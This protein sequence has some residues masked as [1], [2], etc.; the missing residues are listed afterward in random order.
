MFPR[1][2]DGF[3]TPLVENS[4]MGLG[5][6]FDRPKLFGVCLKFGLNP[7][8]REDIK[9][10]QEGGKNLTH[11]VQQLRPD[12]N[13]SCLPPH[14]DKRPPTSSTRRHDCQRSSACDL[15]QEMRRK[16]TESPPQ[17][18]IMSRSS[19][20]TLSGIGR[21]AKV[22]LGGGLSGSMP[23]MFSTIT[24]WRTCWPECHVVRS[25]YSCTVTSP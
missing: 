19:S 2:L 4:S 14:W 23:N 7:P 18:Q 10:N 6:H 25:R 15:P 21:P 16:R 12:E 22:S 11:A 3:P 20:Q 24:S 8:I 13:S 9:P 17:V 5:V 1:F